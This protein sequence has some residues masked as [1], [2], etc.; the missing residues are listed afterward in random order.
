MLHCRYS[1]HVAFLGS[2]HIDSVRLALANFV[3]NGTPVFL[4]HIALTR[5][6]G[7]AEGFFR[8]FGARIGTLRAY[9]S[10]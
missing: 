1:V 4:G 5:D 8:G 6:D 10:I 7:P 2:W 3:G 9:I